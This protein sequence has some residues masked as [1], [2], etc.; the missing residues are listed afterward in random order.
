MQKLAMFKWKLIIVS[1]FEAVL[2]HGIIKPCSSGCRS[3][4]GLVHDIVDQ[5]LTIERAKIFLLAVACFHWLDICV[6]PSWYCFKWETRVTVV[7]IFNWNLYLY[8]CTYNSVFK[9]AFLFEKF[10]TATSFPWP[11]PYSGVLWE[12]A[13]GMRLGCSGWEESDTGRQT[14]SKYLWQK[15]C[16]TKCSEK[17][18]ML[19][20]LGWPPH[21]RGV[22]VVYMIGGLMKLHIGT[23]PPP[24]KKIKKNKW[25]WNFKYLLSKFPTPKYKRLKKQDYKIIHFIVIFISI[26][27]EL[28]FCW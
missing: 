4:S 17:L 16:C 10:V 22:L 13:M 6:V 19:T 11:L 18:W 26:F 5:T 2:A 27:L 21:P 7:S 24:K 25:P 9:C 1:S 23:P 20:M 12:K 3:D 28:T 15:Q 8:I 14:L